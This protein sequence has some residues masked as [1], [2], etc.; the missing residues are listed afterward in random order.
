MYGDMTAFLTIVTHTRRVI[1][2][3]PRSDVIG[4]AGKFNFFGQT[5]SEPVAVSVTEIYTRTH[6]HKDIRTHSLV[7]GYY[8][9]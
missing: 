9:Y 7:N 5:G 6:T 4:A 3:L 1:A 2:M 8:S